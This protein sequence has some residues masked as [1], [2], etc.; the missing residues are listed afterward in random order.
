MELPEI[1]QK[2]CGTSFAYYGWGQLLSSIPRLARGAVFWSEVKM[3]KLTG[4]VILVTAAIAVGLA[5]PAKADVIYDLTYYNGSTNLGTGVLDLNFTSVAQAD[6]LN[7]SLSGILVSITTPNLD[8]TGSYTVTPSNL[9]TGSNI[10]TGAQAQIYALTVPEVEPGSDKTGATNILF[11][12]LYTNTWQ[13]HGKYDS[14]EYDGRLVVGAPSDPPAAVPEPLTL[15]LFGAGL[16][17]AAAL[18]RRKK[19]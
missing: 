7:E 10:T 11:L 14:Q 15:S 13:L 8:G 17:G 2:W 9:D 12:D 6:N 1:L 19:A 3:L 4:S 5:A 16:A 18:R